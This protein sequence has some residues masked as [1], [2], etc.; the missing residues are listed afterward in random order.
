MTNLEY[1][2]I[3]M[4]INQDIEEEKNNLTRKAI[5][6]AIVTA[7][8][9]CIREFKT[10]GTG[11]II[12]DFFMVIGFICSISAAILSTATSSYLK[13]RRKKLDELF[14]KQVNAGEA[15]RQI[16]AIKGTTLTVEIES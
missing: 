13:D 9:I 5:L 7:L 14:Q 4:S 1:L 6:F 2:Q 3:K 16:N 8:F 12:I 10:P 11:D 15:I